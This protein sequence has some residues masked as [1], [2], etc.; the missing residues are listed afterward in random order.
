VP[1]PFAAEAHACL[2]AIQ[3]GIHLGLESVIIEGDSMTTI[4]KCSSENPDKSVI[5]AIIRDI[6]R[7]KEHFQ[8]A[9]FQY[10]PKSANLLAHTLAYESLKKGEEFYLDGHLPYLVRRVLEMRRQRNPD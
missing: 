9:V 4:K 3:L 1:S 10:T 7:Q 5:G 2:Q 8:R 6:H